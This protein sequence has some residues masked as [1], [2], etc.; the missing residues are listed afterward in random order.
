MEHFRIKNKV[1]KS[2]IGF[3]CLMIFF[4]A[5]SFLILPE[6][7]FSQEKPLEIEYPEIK[8]VKPETVDIGI[9]EYVKYIFNFA[10]II[11][12]LIA[13]VILIIGGISYISSAGNPE[14]LTRAKQRIKSGFL[15]VLILLASYLV[16]YTINPQLI[17]FDLPELIKLD[18][19]HSELPEVSPPEDPTILG[20][21]AQIAQ[22]IKIAAGG[23]EHYS[24]EILTLVENCDCQN[25]WSVCLTPNYYG[26]CG[27]IK[28]YF[29]NQSH[30]CPD[31]HKIKIAQQNII[32]F[33]KEILYYKNKIAA[34]KQDL[35]FESVELEKQINY[36]L[37]KIEAEEQFLSEIPSDKEGLIKEQ[38][39]KIEYL[40][41]IRNRLNAEY[42]LNLRVIDALDSLFTYIE[43][44][45]PLVIKLAEPP[46]SLVD[47]CWQGVDEVCQPNC[48]GGGHDKE[49][50]FSEKC[51]GGNPCKT[52]EI[53][54]TIELIKEIIEPIIT[55]CEDV[56]DANEEFKDIDRIDWL[57]PTFS[58]PTDYT[59]P[60]NGSDPALP[61]VTGTASASDLLNN[62]KEICILSGGTVKEG[63]CG[64]RPSDIHAQSVC[65]EKY[66]IE[67]GPDPGPSPESEPK[68]SWV[69]PN[70]CLLPY[71]CPLKGGG[72]VTAP[73]ASNHRG[74]DI[75]KGEGVPL[76]ATANGTIEKIGYEGTA[77]LTITI[78]H[79]GGYKTRYVH[80]KQETVNVGDFVYR[81]DQVGTM[82]GVP[83]NFTR[84]QTIAWL[85][86]GR[87]GSWTSSGTPK[88]LAAGRSTGAHIHYDIVY[89]GVWQNTNLS[90]WGICGNINCTKGATTV[91]W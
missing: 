78:N 20:R 40:D 38:E 15:G 30:P 22:D 80:T 6:K 45:T 57:P 53:E 34:E 87:T 70:I 26:A 41:G 74:I 17:V 54:S 65:C 62:A 55:I 75:A 37:E 29:N 46:D 44:L 84:D 47:S 63:L 69:E 12:G 89:N 18:P 76:Y 49:G 86:R 66:E 39:K 85:N 72:W 9:V 32:A 58:D 14:K 61:C 48:S 42:G 91:S 13:F 4:I 51:S 88:S 3:F 82:G 52:D 79:G 16:L 56:F 77:G 25:V 36:Y 68:Y 27:G 5:L 7:T 11:V 31:W 60:G 19:Y 35:E 83:S 33:K 2:I 10:I 59:D 23:I 21:I 50:C 71:G 43:D 64:T 67:P 28:C 90:K 8:D 73:Y 1:K 24:E 81:G